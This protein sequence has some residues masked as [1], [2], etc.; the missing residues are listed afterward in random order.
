MPFVQ[1]TGF[2]KKTFRGDSEK[3]RGILGAIG[4]QNRF[5]AIFRCPAKLLKFRTQ[6]LGP[7]LIAMVYLSKI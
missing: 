7:S 1:P 4:V 6:N 5:P 3:L 2:L